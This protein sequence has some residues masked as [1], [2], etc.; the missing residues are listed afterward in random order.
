MTTKLSKFAA[1]LLLGT[2]L[3]LG[4]VTAIA[5]MQPAFAQD[6]DQTRDCDKLQDSTCD[7]SKDQTKD[8][9]KLNDTTADQDRT[10]DQDKLHDADQDKDQDQTKDQDKLNDTT[11]DRGRIRTS[12]TTLTRPRIRTWTSSMTRI[13]T[14]ITISCRLMTAPVRARRLARLR[15]AATRAA[16]A[17]TNTYM[18]GLKW[19]KA[20]RKRRLFLVECYDG[21]HPYDDRPIAFSILH[22]IRINTFEC[23]KRLA[24]VR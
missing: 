9:D 21:I 10:K 17:R 15:A 14:G 18:I 7:Q 20:A 23:S 16:K 24:L 11:A 4:S 22:S 2:G 3:V 12:C 8:Q 13:W 6:R 1:Q 5:A 19:N